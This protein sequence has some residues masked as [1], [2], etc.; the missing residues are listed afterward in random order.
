MPL[1][2]DLVGHLR[3]PLGHGEFAEYLPSGLYP[4][5]DF[6]IWLSTMASDQAWEC[7]K[8]RKKRR[9]AFH[10]VLVNLARVFLRQM[11]LGFGESHWCNGNDSDYWLHKLFRKWN[12]SRSTILTF[13]YDTLIEH[14]FVLTGDASAEKTVVP[15]PSIYPIQLPNFPTTRAK[16]FSTSTRAPDFRLY[17][18]HGSVNWWRKFPSEK[19]DNRIYFWD[20]PQWQWAYGGKSAD[21]APVKEMH[22]P[23]L[24]PPLAEKDR[25]YSVSVLDE[26]WKKAAVKLQQASSLII[27]GYSFPQTDTAAR[28]FFA[29]NLNPRAKVTVVNCSANAAAAAAEVFG[30]SGITVEQFPLS[31]FSIQ[32][33]TEC[34][35]NPPPIQ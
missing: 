24:V 19:N 30:Y 9:E 20:R 6:E 11:E 8:K 35:A 27:M 18:L 5:F 17:K 15:C 12:E 1:V 31:E 14:H 28:A 32:N 2:K 23:F 33:Y 29:E 13:N 7:E 10:A 3:N 22:L 34:L 16:R 21:L 4:D 25:F 26:L